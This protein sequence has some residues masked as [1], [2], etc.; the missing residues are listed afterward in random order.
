MDQ[1]FKTNQELFAVYNS[2]G[3]L[4]DGIYYKEPDCNACLKD[5]L[6]FMRIENQQTFATRRQLGECNFLS[7]DLAPLVKQHC[8]EDSTLFNYVLRLLSSLT[9]PPILLFKEKIPDDI[10]GRKIYLDLQQHMFNYKTELSI[11]VMFWSVIA[12]KMLKILQTEQDDRQDEDKEMLE[13]MLVL[14]RNVLHVESQDEEDV[15]FGEDNTHD[16]LLIS[17]KKAFIFDILIYICQTETEHEF[18]F[19]ILE[20]YQSIFR[21][22]DPE[23]LATLNSSLCLSEAEKRRGWLLY[24]TIIWIYNNFNI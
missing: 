19:Y 1:S 22:Q 14:I 24:L 23:I 4:Q 17:M 15:I 6:R 11:D 5:I 8:L 2:L 20:I 7:T 16:K 18:V 3:H 9:I 12:K 21:E 13:R 10:D